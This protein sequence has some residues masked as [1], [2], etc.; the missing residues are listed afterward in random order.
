MDLRDKIYLIGFSATGKSHSG[1]LAAQSLDADFVDMDRLI[2]TRVGKEISEIFADEGEEAFRRIERDLLKEISEEPGRR[3]ISTGG[4]V[5][6]DQQN[7][8]MMSAH[9]LTIRLTA[10]AETIH[11]RINR[12]FTRRN[13]RQI[14]VRPMLAGSDSDGTTVDRVRELLAEREVAYSSAEDVSIDTEGRE[15]KDVAAEIVALIRSNKEK[16]EAKA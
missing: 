15:P 10:S 3:V 2:V 6:V 16:S 7:R 12:P 11:E 9:G 4:G 8:E 5:P 1:R 14:A 13:R